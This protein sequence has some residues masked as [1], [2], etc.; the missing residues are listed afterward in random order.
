M[1]A[2][3]ARQALFADRD[4]ATAGAGWAKRKRPERQRATSTIP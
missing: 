3:S 2:R 4:R 1:G